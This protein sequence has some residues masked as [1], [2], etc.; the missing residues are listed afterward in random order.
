MVAAAI[1]LARL[2]SGV[3]SPSRAVEAADQPGSG[4]AV[5]TNVEH[6]WLPKTLLDMARHQPISTVAE[7]YKDMG[8][9]PKPPGREKLWYALGTRIHQK[10]GRDDHIT[11][12]RHPYGEPERFP[13]FLKVLATASGGSPS[14]STSSFSEAEVHIL[15]GE[16]AE[17][18][19]R[20][21]VQK[22]LSQTFGV[23]EFSTGRT[24]DAK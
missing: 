10:N 15:A 3:I 18:R 9:L 19:P 8:P 6:I 2:N 7:G 5:R 21:V 23:R 4:V 16:Q 11:Y 20:E 12:I 17:G 22:L 1:A 13:E 24:T 14:G